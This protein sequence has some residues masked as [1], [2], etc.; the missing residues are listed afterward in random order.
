VAFSFLGST[1]NIDASVGDMGGK[2]GAPQDGFLVSEGNPPTM[3]S[4]PSVEIVREVAGK[5]DHYTLG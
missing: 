3:I 1:G 5:F 2:S 4:P